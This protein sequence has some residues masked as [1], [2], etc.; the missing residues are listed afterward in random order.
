VNANFGESA[1]ALPP[2][3]WAKSDSATLAPLPETAV[4]TPNRLRLVAAVL[5]ALIAAIAAFFGVR[6][7]A[8]LATEGAAPVSAG[9]IV[10]V[11]T[12]STDAIRPGF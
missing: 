10:A 2:P 6:I 3:P 4:E 5:V 7:I 8:D 11:Q 9:S 12:A 1:D